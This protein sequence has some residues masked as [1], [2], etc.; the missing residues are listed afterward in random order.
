MEY[1]HI[2]DMLRRGCSARGCRYAGKLG[3]LAHSPCRMDR[4]LDRGAIF[5]GSY[6]RVPCPG[7]GS[8]LA[9]SIVAREAL[10]PA[11]ARGHGEE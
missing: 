10:A 3:H 1:G 6:H 2:V 11:D 5:H 7:C 4:C 9:S 8:C